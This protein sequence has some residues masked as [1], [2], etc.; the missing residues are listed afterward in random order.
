MF[1]PSIQAESSQEDCESSYEI[2]E[3]CD[4]D[5][6]RLAREHA[7]NIADTGFDARHTVHALHDLL[8]C[9]N[10][11]LA[12]LSVE[13]GGWSVFDFSHTIEH[14]Y[15]LLSN[16]RATSV[17]CATERLPVTLWAGHLTAQLSAW[18]I[19][20]ILVKTWHVR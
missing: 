20:F 12:T 17:E 13:T 3:G 2:L 7:G 11:T 6:W 16:A 10:L 8:E 9:V 19:G 1:C 15:V 4:F 5:R 14:C 18:H